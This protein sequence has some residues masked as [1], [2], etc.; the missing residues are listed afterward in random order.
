MLKNKIINRR[1][2][3]CYDLFNEQTVN[4][5]I[6]SC[7]QHF[8][9]NL[10]LKQSTD[11]YKV[12]NCI[13]DCHG[14]HLTESREYPYC[15]EYWNIFCKTVVDKVGDYITYLHP[16]L[17]QR[18]WKYINELKNGFQIFPHSCWSIKILP[19]TNRYRES[20]CLEKSIDPV[21][22]TD[23]F[24]T[25][26]YYLQNSNANNGTIIKCEGSK[27][28]KTEGVE[29]SLFIF[30]DHEFGEY[31]SYDIE[32][33]SKTIIRFDFCILNEQHEVPWESPRVIETIFR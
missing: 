31:Q 12:T 18:K 13:M 4:D 24:I 6:N 19:D 32:D 11:L 14:L 22:T 21:F 20:F 26:I 10:N 1:F 28:Y 33:G 3:Q 5:L 7:E 29:N 30:R 27:Y 16:E 2:F 25:A 9:E 15:Q 23:T 8:E 17:L